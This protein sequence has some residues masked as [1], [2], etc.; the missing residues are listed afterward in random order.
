[1]NGDPK[2]KVTPSQI[3]WV[4]A[5]VVLLTSLF[6]IGAWLFKSPEPEGPGGKNGAGEMTEQEVTPPAFMP[7]G[8]GAGAPQPLPSP[9]LETPP[10]NG[11]IPTPASLA[12]RVPS[13]GTQKPIR[14]PE[15]TDAPPLS[16]TV[17]P[18]A[19]QGQPPGTGPAKTETPP[20]KSPPSKVEKP[21]AGAK[22]GTAPRETWFLQAAAVSDRKKAVELQKQLEAK[23]FPS[24]P[25]VREGTLYKVRIPYR[26][27]GGARAAKKK[28]DDAG[29]RGTEGSFVI[30]PEK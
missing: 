29:V 9:S 24:A 8:Q 26:D 18:P 11:S 16:A 4:A 3:I 14:E 12:P 6:L 7:E 22:G 27:E 2:P 10:A 19:K 23:G 1:M 21:A 15:K 20:A 17:V 28:L 30:K 25:L 5:C 13:Q